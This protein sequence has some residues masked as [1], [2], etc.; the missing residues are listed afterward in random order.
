MDK[1]LF[2]LSSSR[3][4]DSGY[5]E[6]ALTTVREFLPEDIRELLF[7]PY[8][9]VSISFDEYEVMVQQ[10]FAPVEIHVT[11][12]HHASDPR[13]AVRK[14]KAIA[15]GGGNTFAL[16]RR[17]QDA[18]LI[19]LVRERVQSGVHY[20]G[21]SAGS[22]VA[23]PT[24]CTTNDM[25]ITEP[26]TFKAFDLFPM[27]V[28]PHFISGKPAGHNGESREDRLTEFLALNPEKKLIALPEGT[29]LQV[30]N[31]QCRVV[32]ENPA[33][34]ISRTEEQ[35]F[36]IQSIDADVDFRLSEFN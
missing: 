6:T 7:I 23:G 18:D 19:N 10:A 15:V 2:L 1:N 14:A 12:I 4:G 13:E 24:I 8:A 34:L 5:L 31:N 3:S 32:G 29:A 28:N 22:N 26:V 11:S 9:G 33:L 20:I 27:Q 25:P 36:I 21:W 35:P 16:L 30:R 17:L